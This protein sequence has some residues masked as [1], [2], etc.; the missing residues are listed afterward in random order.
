MPR[1]VV[2]V[3]TF[4]GVHAGHAALIARARSIADRASG[5]EV[6]VLAFDPHPATR[7]HPESA[8]PRLGSFER[9]SEL[10][11]QA[12]ADRVERLEPTSEL[13]SQSP[14][15]FVESIA[16]RLAP[17]AFVEGPDFRFGKGRTGD[18]S[19][20]ASI[21][22]RHGFAVD[23]VPPVAVALNDQSVVTASS[24]IARWLVQHGRVRDAWA[25]LT[26]PHELTGRVVRGDRRGR[27]LGFPTANLDTP[28]LPPAD[29]VYA[30]VAFLDDGRSFPAAVSVGSKPMFNGAARAVEASLLD[31]PT[32]DGP[33]L[34]G[35]PE[36]GW[37]LRI[38]LVGWVRE[39]LRFESVDSLIAQMHRDCNRVRG[40]VAR[41]STPQPAAAG[42]HS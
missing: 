9:R 7:L 35:L 13:L 42:A 6:V 24:T 11:R 22:K 37:N 23:V 33:C 40:I 30:G 12:G 25:V 19:V 20:L 17:I 16:D 1:S 29:G 15:S 2:S 18:T 41:V 36:Y 39:Q 14:E 31:A 38:A 3:G 28:C 4:D 26:R 32:G 21:G 10:L 27:G 5:A 8:P 34:A